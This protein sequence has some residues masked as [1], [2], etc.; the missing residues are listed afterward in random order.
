[1]ALKWPL[2]L[3]CSEILLALRLNFLFACSQLRI[4]HCLIVQKQNLISLL[5]FNSAQLN[6]SHHPVI[7][8]SHSFLKYKETRISSMYKTLR[9]LPFSWVA[10]PNMWSALCF[11]RRKGNFC[12]CVLPRNAY[13]DVGACVS[14][15]LP[16]S[17]HV[18]IFLCA[19]Q[20]LS[21]TIN[22]H[23]FS[24]CASTDTTE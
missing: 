3:S 14:S 20:T 1:M 9:Q 5:Q 11:V 23:S 12:S 15:L 4:L 21:L 8:S 17:A 2:S 19:G 6:F 16:T 10:V 13:F 7:F 18:Y 22:S 24:V